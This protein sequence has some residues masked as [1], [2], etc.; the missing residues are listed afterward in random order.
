MRERVAPRETSAQN[1]GEVIDT[2]SGE[3]IP[4]TPRD[5]PKASPPRTQP[6]PSPLSTKHRDAADIMSDRKR[7]MSLTSI[8]ELKTPKAAQEKLPFIARLGRSWSRRL[9]SSS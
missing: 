2:R 4:T 3:M 1:K 7:S 5:S 8:D 6:A 9:S